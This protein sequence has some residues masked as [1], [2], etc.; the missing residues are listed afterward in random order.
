VKDGTCH[1]RER[2][3]EKKDKID[4]LMGEDAEFLALCEDYD[5]CVNAFQYW[6]N[7]KGP[8]AEIRTKEYRDLTLE[9]EEEM[10]QSLE[11]MKAP[12][13]D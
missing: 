8:E 9:L 6:S 7:S 12:H 1:S 11:S 10:T 2:F 13:L 3:P 5:V 4:L